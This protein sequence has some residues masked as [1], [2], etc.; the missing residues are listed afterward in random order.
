MD[1]TFFYISN[2]FF[3]L[4]VS[5]MCGSFVYV[6]C[7]ERYYKNRFVLNLSGMSSFLYY[8]SLF[9]S[10]IIIAVFFVAFSNLFVYLIMIQKVEFEIKPFLM[11]SFIGY[12]WLVAFIT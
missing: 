6:P 5:F 3:F 10:D 2:L 12:T 11:A 8:F 9:L 7:F 1:S 4:A